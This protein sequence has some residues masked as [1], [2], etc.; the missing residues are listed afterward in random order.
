[1]KAHTLS[2]KD[3]ENLQQLRD[4]LAVQTHL[5]KAEARDSWGDLE[6]RWEQ[7]QAQMA[8][9]QQSGAESATEIHAA[10]QLLADSI[11]NGYQHLRDSMRA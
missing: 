10:T 2:L 3:I 5:M 1:M 7:L 9:L 4:E 8:T 11:R 6:K